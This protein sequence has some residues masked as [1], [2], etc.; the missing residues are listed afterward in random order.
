MNEDQDAE[1]EL[2]LSCSKA[3]EIRLLL[4]PPVILMSEADQ[5]LEFASPCQGTFL[6]SETCYLLVQLRDK[7]GESL[8][9][10]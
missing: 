2:K 1:A 10:G 5:L 3:R 4:P 8:I 6:R 9:S 7:D